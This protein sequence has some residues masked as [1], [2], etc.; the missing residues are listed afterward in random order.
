MKNREEILKKIQEEAKLLEIPES[1]TPETMRKVLK[2]QEAQKESEKFQ[3]RKRI[4][5]ALVMAACFCVVIGSVYFIRDKMNEPDAVAREDIAAEEEFQ[6]ETVQQDMKYPEI[7]YHDVYA[8]MSKQWDKFIWDTGREIPEGMEFTDGIVYEEA[9][10]ETEM[11]ANKQ[12][13]AISDLAADEFGTTNVQTEG[14]EEGDIVKND[15]RYLYQKVQ[16]DKEYRTDWGIQIVDTQNG[17]EKVSQIE[18]ISGIVE[19]YVWEDVLVVIEE[20][21]LDTAANASRK[22][23]AVIDVAYFDN[24]YQ[25]ITFFD[26]KD[27]KEPKKIKTF[28]LQGSYASSRIADGYFYGFGKYYASP[29]AGE[30]DYDAYIP[31]LDGVHLSESRIYLPADSKAT[32]YLVLAAV[33]LRNPVEFTDTTGIITGA[34]LYYVSGEHIYVTDVQEIGNQEGWNANSTVI[35]KFAYGDGKFFVET[36]GEVN[37]MLESSFSMDEYQDHL[38][39]VSTV[40]EY[41]QIQ[42]KDDRTG[43]IIGSEIVNERRSNALYVLDENLQVVGKIEGLAE[44]EQIYSARF[45]G[46]TGYFVTFRQTDP[47]FTVDLS[48]SSNPAVLSELKISGFSEYL[49]VYGEDRLLGI[50][51]EADE[52]TGRQQGMKLS[53]FDISDKTDVKEVTKLHLEHCDYSEALYNHRAV[54]ISTGK[55]LFGFEAEG[56]GSD[57]YFKEY[58]VYSYENDE[59]IQRL[60][61]STKDEDGGYY[62]VRGTFIGDIFYLLSMNGAVRSFDLNTGIQ[63]DSLEP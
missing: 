34:D 19:F 14:V 46:D 15:G 36:K 10:A 2:Q 51:M 28:T 33:D 9:A 63:L 23:Y 58:L 24:A 47:L 4:P 59:F 39:V 40:W 54:M 29:G 6:E 49:H 13:N 7:S 18:G 30:E 27:R 11:G 16:I 22:E 41:E 21:Y 48:D 17:L 1:I 55:N 57:E 38:R 50:G 37:G 5:K 53:M 8:S 31:K 44:N 56:I 61:I 25:K 26:I 62:A 32:S 60:K 43:E 20:K 12:M 35:L 42:V 45:M 52:E 3:K